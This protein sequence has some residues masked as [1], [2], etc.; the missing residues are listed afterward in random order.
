[1]RW[2][3]W[4]PQGAAGRRAPLDE[5]RSNY[6][7]LCRRQ[8]GRV[9]EVHAIEDRD[10]DGVP[11]RIYRPTT[12]GEALPAL[13]YLHGGG[14][15]IGC[16]DSHDGITRALAR[17]AGRRRVRRVPARARAS[18]TPPALADAWTAA[19]WVFEH[20]AE[21]GIDPERW[22]SAA[23][24]R[25]GRWRRSWR[26]GATRTCRSPRSCCSTR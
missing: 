9:D 8:F 7:E 13:V 26:E 18:S 4:R 15:V 19:R 22:A 5:A 17:R 20:A 14:W 10:A 21:L 2:R 1:V 24:A 16:I 3:R 23:T 6:V 12:S 25:A 11:V